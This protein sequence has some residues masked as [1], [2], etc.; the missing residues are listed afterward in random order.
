MDMNIWDDE[1]R[2]HTLEKTLNLIYDPQ[3]YP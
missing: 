3:N 2:I 1:Y